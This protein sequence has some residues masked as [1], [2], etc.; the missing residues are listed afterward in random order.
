MKKVLLY[1]I[2]FSKTN[3]AQLKINKVAT[4]FRH[5]LNLS[6]FYAAAKNVTIDSS[7]PVFHKE[8]KMGSA[9]RLS[10]AA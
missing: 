4:V 2:R 8:Y 5:S 3:V 10:F 7:D 6:T 9:I 1:Y